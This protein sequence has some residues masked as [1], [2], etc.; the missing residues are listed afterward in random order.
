MYPPKVNINGTSK[1]ELVRQFLE[2]H[3]ALEAAYKA[4]QDCYP[5]GRDFQTQSPEIYRLA[6]DQHDRWLYNLAE[7]RAGID[8]IGAEILDN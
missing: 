2:C 6:R 7:M 3:E 5:H 4:M 1:D 8:Q